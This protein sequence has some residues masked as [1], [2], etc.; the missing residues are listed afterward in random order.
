ME[1]GKADVSRHIEEAIDRVVK[2]G[3]TQETTRKQEEG[4][5][6]TQRK[7]DECIPTAQVEDDLT[8]Q[9]DEILEMLEEREEDGS[10]YEEET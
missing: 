4:I 10:E 3:D 9:V 6:E 1:K 2:N 5:T 8:R 7:Q